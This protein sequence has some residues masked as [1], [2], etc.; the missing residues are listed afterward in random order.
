MASISPN[1]FGSA[2]YW[3]RPTSRGRAKRSTRSLSPARRATSPAPRTTSPTQQVKSPTPKAPDPQRSVSPYTA[4][5]TTGTAAIF[6]ANGKQG[7]QSK[8]VGHPSNTA[9][10]SSTSTYTYPFQQAGLAQPT[11]HMN[12]LHDERDKTDD[13]AMVKLMKS[14][15]LSSPTNMTGKWHH[16]NLL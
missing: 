7:A 2:T 3:N 1:G 4:S 16:L 11:S 10:L 15:L 5:Q 9:F 12:N 6:S 14:I 8:V 13:K